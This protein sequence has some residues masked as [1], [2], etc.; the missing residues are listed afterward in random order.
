MKIIAHRSG[1]TKFPEQTVLSAL[2]ARTQGADMV[3]VDVR[4]TKDKKIV[5]SH[6]ENAQRI[7]GVDKKICEMNEEEF[8]SLSHQENPEFSSHC[9]EDYLQKEIFPLLIHV[10]EDELLDDLLATIE[11]YSCQNQVV[12][13][14]QSIAAVEKVKKFNQEINVLAFIP[15]LESME[16]F[17]QTQADYIRL[18]EGWVTIDRI[19]CIR[20]YQKEVWVMTNDGEVGVTTSENLAKITAL[21]VD[22]ILINDIT[23]LLNQ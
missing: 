4:Y 7:F 10:K 15:N 2:L 11:T 5:I 1:P 6:D 8:L 19:E 13:G 9:F 16:E 14:V 17:G 21:G 18:W 3:E 23:Q 22:G 20:K 12:L